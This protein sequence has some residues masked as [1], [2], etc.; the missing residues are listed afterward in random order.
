MDVHGNDNRPEWG[1]CQE[2]GCEEAAIP[3]YRA[4]NAY[5]DDPDDLLCPSHAPEY[6]Y[7]WN[8]GSEGAVF[9]DDESPLPEEWSGACRACIKDWHD[10]EA[11]ERYHSHLWDV[12]R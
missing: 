8:C 6:D 9:G 4:G 12:G 11:T 2:E 5:P 7:C 10:T 3:C 1:Y